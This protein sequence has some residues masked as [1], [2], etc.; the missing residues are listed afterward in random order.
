MFSYQNGSWVRII[1]ALGTNHLNFGYESSGYETSM[2]TKREVQKVEKLSF[3]SHG[4]GPRMA[5]FSSFFFL[6][7][8]GSENVFHDILERQ[9]NFLG[10]KNMKSKKS[11]IWDFS[12]GG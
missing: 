8:I 1:L 12:K 2:G 9:N 5:F 7:N 10:Y 4:F 11:N 3:L 6:G